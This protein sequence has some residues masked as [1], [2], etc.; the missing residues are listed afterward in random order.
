MSFYVVDT[1]SNN[2]H[3][4]DNVTT[5]DEVII[6]KN[7]SNDMSNDNSDSNLEL[8]KFWPKVNEEIDS[9]VTLDWKQQL[10]P[11]ARIKKIMKLDE[12]VK[13]ISAEAPLLFAKACEIF[14]CELTLRA[15]IHTEENKRRTLQRSDIA[16]AI[17]KYDQFDFLIDIVPRE[18]IKAA[19]PKDET[20]VKVNADQV[21]YYVQLTQPQ[22]NQ[23]STTQQSQT[24]T[25]NT[26]VTTAATGIQIVQPQIQTVQLN[27]VDNSTNS[28]TQNSTTPIAAGAFQLLQQIVTPTGEIQHIPIQLSAQQLQMIR[29]QVPTVASANTGNENIV[30]TSSVSATTAS[31]VITQ[32]IIIQAQP[33]PNDQ[34]HILQVAQSA[35]T[36]TN[37]T[38]TAPTSSE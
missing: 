22:T 4:D 27:S 9:I 3:D 1:N 2:N 10:L 18:E 32:P 7:S 17:S 23:T 6:T 16:L 30:T 37:T 11:L 26:T 29:M 5:N 8:A 12:E 33:H 35:P 19:R 13:M 14:I 31:T 15:W 36:V 38:T 34:T 28:T 24:D 20:N 21:Q 25:T